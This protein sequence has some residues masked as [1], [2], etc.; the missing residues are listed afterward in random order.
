[1]QKGQ[2]CSTSE[3]SKFLNNFVLSLKYSRQYISVIKILIRLL[4]PRSSLDL[5]NRFLS[6]LL[7]QIIAIGKQNLY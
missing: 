2:Q 3:T 5:E 7:E 4:I 1:M 6:V